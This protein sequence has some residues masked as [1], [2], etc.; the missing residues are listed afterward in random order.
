MKCPNCGST[1]I[2]FETR[3][4]RNCGQSIDAAPQSAEAREGAKRLQEIEKA[5]EAIV[6]AKTEEERRAAYESWE[7]KV[8]DAYE[9]GHRIITLIGYS[10]AG[11]TFLAHRLRY[12]LADD[13]TVWPPPAEVIRG[14]GATIELTQ[15]TSKQPKP[16][17]RMLADCDGEAYKKFGEAAA[18]NRDVDYTERRA[19]VMGGCASAYILVIP[20]AELVDRKSHEGTAVLTKRFGTIVQVLMALQRIVVEAGGPRQALR[21]GL[22][23]DA[24]ATALQ[25]EY[26]CQ[27]P[28]HVLFAKADKLPKDQKYA[29]DPHMFALA[30]AKPLYRTIESNFP[31]FRYD[32]VCAFDGHDE[33]NAY[34]VDYELPCYGAVAAF[35][36]IDRMLDAAPHERNRTAAAMQIRRR[37]DGEFR[38]LAEKAS[39]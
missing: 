32:F 22:K 15:F 21:G 34:A 33:A 5:S 9:Q 10:D 38:K 7:R 2:N 6:L 3:T 30:Y 27:Q 37:F 11:K 20:A 4:C 36:W 12:E 29:G 35:D 14:T 28:I 18:Q 13:W 23:M 19:V 1:D 8:F 17:V 39:R 16:R 24:V 31:A 26:R 25:H